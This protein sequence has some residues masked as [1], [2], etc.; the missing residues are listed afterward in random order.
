MGSYNIMWKQ[1]IF[2][3]LSKSDK[4]QPTNTE[5][6]WDVTHRMDWLF[7]WTEMDQLGQLRRQGRRWNRSW[8]DKFNTWQ[9]AY[10]ATH[11]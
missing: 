2:F 1:Q 6:V 9:P 11:L 5:A 8:L 3:D 7:G 4:N 10:L